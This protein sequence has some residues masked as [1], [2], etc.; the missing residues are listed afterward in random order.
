MGRISDSELRML[1]FEASRKDPTLS[2]TS[3]L[4]G[5]GINPVGLSSVCMSSSNHAIEA[6]SIADLV[7]RTRKKRSKL[8]KPRESKLMDWDLVVEDWCKAKL[9]DPSL[10]VAR[11]AVSTGLNRNTLA[12]KCVGAVFEA[13]KK[14]IED[15]ESGIISESEALSI[16]ELRLKY[17]RV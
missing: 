3:F 10:S 12:A 14:Q 7:A 8:P 5:L 11:F 9:I 1:W 16:Y 13:Y 6:T 2:K 15:I 4:A 17:G